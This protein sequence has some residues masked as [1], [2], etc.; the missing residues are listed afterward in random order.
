MKYG[1][2]RKSLEGRNCF[3]KVTASGCRGKCC[4]GTVEAGE[5]MPSQTQKASPNEPHILGLLDRRQ[6]AALDLTSIIDRPKRVS[7]VAVSLT[8]DGTHAVD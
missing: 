1:E 8:F 7:V 5:T 3:A 2:D 4:L 6:S